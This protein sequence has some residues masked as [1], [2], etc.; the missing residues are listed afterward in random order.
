[1]NKA[2]ICTTC[3]T[4]Y[5][6]DKEVPDLCT[7][8]NDDRQYIAENGQHWT[9]MDE[10]KKT[11]ATRVEL[12]AEQIY[13]LRVQ[14]DF[15]LTNRALLVKSAGGNILWDCIPLPDAETIDFI[16]A[17]GGLKAIVFS[18][19]HYYSTMNEWAS[20]FNCPVYIHE[21]D[22]EWI[23]YNNEH[24]HLWSGQ[25]QQLWDDIRI[26]HTGGHFPGSCVLHIPALS[27][28]GTILCG[29]S[30]YISCSKRHTAVMYSYPNQILLPRNEF[31]TF[32]QKWDGIT[33]DTMYG[34]FDNQD[35][36]GNAMQVFEVSM[37][38]Y[39]KSYGL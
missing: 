23:K 14:P 21:N 15:A 18:H 2:L 32:Y 7:I 35:L 22:R 12:I 29:D 27:E 3:G 13:S 6:P 9:T 28:K 36:K 34:A 24:I 31:A 16:K 38:R 17:N 19:P 1:M 25:T 20:L 5:P 39:K 30:L 4:Q 26:I 37:Q 10:L 8:C 11:Y 33:F